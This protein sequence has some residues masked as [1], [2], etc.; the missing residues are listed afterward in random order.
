MRSIL[1]S[2]FLV[3]VVLVGYALAG[4]APEVT[5]SCG[6]H[7]SKQAAPAAPSCQG[8]AKADSCH[9]RTTFAQRRAARQEE[10]QEA[11]AAARAARAQA[12]ASCHGQTQPA[13]CDCCC[14]V[15]ED[16]G[17]N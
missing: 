9:G 8:E 13:A 2:A 17:C 12:R 3:S 6:C 1:L 5:D 16:C 14:E 7:G 11:R 4:A 10:R 15:K